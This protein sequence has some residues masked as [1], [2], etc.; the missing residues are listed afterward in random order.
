MTKVTLIRMS[1]K[2]QNKRQVKDKNENSITGAK[3]SLIL[4]QLWQIKLSVTSKK[5]T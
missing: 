3:I 2:P 5:S 1:L 4:A